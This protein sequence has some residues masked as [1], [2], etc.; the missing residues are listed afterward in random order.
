MATI[1]GLDLGKFKSVACTY[2]PGTTAARFA[3]IP[4]DPDDLRELLEAERPDLVVF[5]TCTVA[6]WVADICAEL[7]LAY[8]VAN[9]MQRG[10]ELAQGQ[11]QDRPRRR[12]EAGP[13]GGPRRAAHRADALARRPASTAPWSQYRDRLVGR[14]T[15]GQNRIRALAQRAGPARCRRA[16][17]PGPRPAW[18]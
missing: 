11:A 3:T 16:T 18:S 12:P 7:G 17:G 10:L 2:D 1:L 14:R 15:A 13:H 6:G 8:L 5:E 4:T 9:P